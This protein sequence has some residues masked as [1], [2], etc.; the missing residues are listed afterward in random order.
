MLLPAG[1]IAVW[2]LAAVV[3]VFAVITAQP[4]GA[5]VGVL[6]LAATAIRVRGRWLDR[7]LM[8]Y[9]TYRR[10]ERLPRSATPL[11]AV[12]P[13][14]AIS[15]FTDRAGNR[16]GLASQGPLWTAVLR[17]E[18]VNAA[19]H[20]ELLGELT[21]ALAKQSDARLAAV[22]LVRWAVPK[23]TDPARAASRGTWDV[24][25][26]AVKFDP[27]LDPAAV[28]TRGGGAEG[29]KRATGIAALRLCF[30]L[31]GRGFTVHPLD[32]QELPDEL[33]SSLG[34]GAQSPKARE[35]WRSWSLGSLQHAAF[36]IRTGDPAQVLGWQARPPALTTATSVLM[37]TS[38]RGPRVTTTL[39]VA[40]SADRKNSRAVRAAL[41]QATKGVGATGAKAK[42]MNGRHR[43]GVR[44]TIPLGE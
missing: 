43:A 36:T 26:I 33:A 3:V 23:P 9:L 12:A 40:V 22:Q 13:G 16:V 25:W 14:L 8:V 38:E 37:S 29:A 24:L 28:A 5:V 34:A 31:R 27:A 39:R 19:Q 32:D 10:R 42:A 21:Q 20:G 30:Q 17:L 44:A 15:V 2:Q 35:T 11:G 6:A 18:K 1:R 41:R 7:W 4:A